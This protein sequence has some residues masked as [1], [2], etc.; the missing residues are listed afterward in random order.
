[1]RQRLLILCSLLGLVACGSSQWRSGENSPKSFEPPQRVYF[2]PYDL[3][4]RAAQI[5]LRYPIQMN[6]M[7]TGLIETE[8][9]RMVD[10]YQAPFETNLKPQGVRYKISLQVVRGNFEGKKS[11]KV[12][13]NKK[14]ERLKNF[15]VE[16]EKLESDLIEERLLLYRVQRELQIEE[17]IRNSN[18]D[19]SA[20]PVPAVQKFEPEGKIYR[21]RGKKKSPPVRPEF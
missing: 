21:Y 4:W 19:G 9:V 5:S 11:V 6:N 18:K 20:P 2:Y 7:D 1:M 15:F 14:M 12:T 13:I 17:G 16:P 3:V 8:W 10:G